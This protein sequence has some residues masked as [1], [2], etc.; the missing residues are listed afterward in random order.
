MLEQIRREYQEIMAADLS[1]YKR[2]VKLAELMT[3][4]ERH[5]RI[6]LLRNP[7]WEKQNPEIIALY[8]Q[9]SNSRK[10]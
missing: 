6:P 3:K 7:E 2:D 10:L 8:R 5:Y 9:I 1:D 4:M